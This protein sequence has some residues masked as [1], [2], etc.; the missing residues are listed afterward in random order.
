MDAVLWKP[1]GWNQQKE[2]SLL[3]RFWV[4]EQE[5]R[6]KGLDHLQLKRKADQAP[7][8]EVAGRNNLKWGTK[9][10]LTG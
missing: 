6:K 10:L 2:A 3:S 5:T 8:E 1:C 4:L 7:T 9:N